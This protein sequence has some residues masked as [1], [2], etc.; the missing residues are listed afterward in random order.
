MGVLR[1]AWP[2]LLKNW[3]RSV[4]EAKVHVS[5]SVLAQDAMLAGWLAAA[6]RA[7][8]DRSMRWHIHMLGRLATSVRPWLP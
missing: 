2:V 7:G 4:A 8:I 1:C 5:G 3:T 6:A